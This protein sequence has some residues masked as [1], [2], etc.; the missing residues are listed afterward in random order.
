MKVYFA[1]ASEKIKEHIEQYGAI[2][3]FIISMGNKINGDWIGRYIDKEADRNVKLDIPYI[4]SE[5][6]DALDDSEVLVADVSIS[7]VSVGYQIG[8]ALSKKIPVLCL[9]SLD[10]GVK[11]PPKVI[12]ASDTTLLKISPYSRKTIHTVIDQ[13]FK[14]IP[15]E[16]MI[17]FNF[18]ITEEI[19][20]FISNGSQKFELSKSGFLRREIEKIINDQKRQ[21]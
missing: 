19:E 13:F 12:E 5:S 4:R 15:N 16:K 9:Y 18:I 11:N 17:K 14:N 1:C 20:E 8:Y 6:L 7:S 2:R 10:F 3:G 21:T